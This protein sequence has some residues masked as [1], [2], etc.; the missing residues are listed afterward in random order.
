MAENKKQVDNTKGR[1]V[2]QDSAI[3]NRRTVV[4]SVKKIEGNVGDKISVTNTHKA[5]DPIKKK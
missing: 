1:T 2:G 4:D 3:A 5:P